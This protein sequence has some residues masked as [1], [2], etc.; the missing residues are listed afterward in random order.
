MEVWIDYLHEVFLKQ[1]MS[2]FS[3]HRSHFF[4]EK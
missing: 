2:Q 4:Q 3:E 1:E